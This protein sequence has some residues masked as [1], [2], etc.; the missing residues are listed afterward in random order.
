MKKDTVVISL[1]SRIPYQTINLD[2]VTLKARDTYLMKQ[3]ALEV[4][5]LVK[6]VMTFSLKM[7][8]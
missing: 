3:V 1:I 7:M 2:Y 8:S 5:L 4:A 6:G